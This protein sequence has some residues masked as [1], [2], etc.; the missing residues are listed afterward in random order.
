[1]GRITDGAVAPGSSDANVVVLARQMGLRGGHR[2]SAGVPIEA[3]NG[4]WSRIF[5][6]RML[7]CV[8]HLWR[9]CDIGGSPAP[10]PSCCRTRTESP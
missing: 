6:L 7:L 10:E 5:S 1:M 8:G 3:G 4:T 9:M 2:A